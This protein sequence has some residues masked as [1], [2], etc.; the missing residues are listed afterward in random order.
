MNFKLIGLIVAAA[1]GLIL[2]SAFVLGKRK[3]VVQGFEGAAPTEGGDGG[4][5]VMYYADWCPHCQSIKPDFKEFM[6]NGTVT[7][8]GKNVKVD[9][10]QPEKEPEKAVGVDVKGYPTLIYS[11]PAGKNFEF[12]GPRTADGFMAFLKEQVVS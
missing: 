1:V 2:L 12:S 9:M 10:V 5:F 8:K 3:N 6:G 7:V 4:K 11:D